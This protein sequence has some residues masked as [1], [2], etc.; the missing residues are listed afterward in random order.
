MRLLSNPY[1]FSAT[2][3]AR[4]VVLFAT[5]MWSAIVLVHP[6][7]LDPSRYPMYAIMTEFASEDVWAGVGLIACAIGIYRIVFHRAPHWC[8][9]LLY[10]GVM[11]FWTYVA[12]TL[13]ILQIHIPP[14]GAS[15]ITAVAVLSVFAFV[16]NP[17]KRDSNDAPGD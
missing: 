8:G 7:A 12:G 10:A 14:G 5:M 16:S 2:I 1:L 13:F 6:N 17:K 11:L 9:S 3:L 4:I 15:C